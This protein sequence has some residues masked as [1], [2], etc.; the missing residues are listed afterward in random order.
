MTHPPGVQ[1]RPPAYLRPHVSP[2]PLIR[3]QIGAGRS[4]QRGN[5]RYH[6]SLFSS[7]PMCSCGLTEVVV[8]RKLVDTSAAYLTTLGLALIIG[9]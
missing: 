8:G 4:R 2:P 1:P 5:A 6:V 3:L 7:K 9:Q